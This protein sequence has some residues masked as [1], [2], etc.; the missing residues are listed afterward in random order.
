VSPDSTVVEEDKKVVAAEPEEVEPTQ[1]V[2]IDGKFLPVTVGA[3]G[4]KQAVDE[5]GNTYILADKK[6]NAIELKR[7]KIMRERYQRLVN[8]GID[9]KKI[10]LMLAEEDYKNKPLDQ[11]FEEYKRLDTA[12]SRRLAQD[13]NA[14]QY[15]DGVLADSMEVNFRAF[16]KMLVK[17]GLSSEDQKLLV[18]EAEEEI[19]AERQHRIE[20][21]KAAAEERAKKMREAK[22]Q[23]MKEELVKAE[24]KELSGLDQGPPPEEAPAP[25]GATVFGG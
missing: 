7:Q 18:K 6:P 13:I 12:M 2:E 23:K 21:Q 15:N 24:G 10:P 19:R 5:N 4:K 9:P 1:M 14:L 25:E 8:K 20:A 17:L 3:D 22:E 11:K 16:A